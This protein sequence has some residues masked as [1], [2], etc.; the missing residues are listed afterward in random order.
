MQKALY[1]CCFCLNTV[2][3]PLVMCHTSHLGCFNCVSE[4]IRHDAHLPN[5][6]I[7]RDTLHIRFDR[8]ISESACIFHRSKRRRVSTSPCAVFVKLLTLKEKNRYKVFTRTF[9]RFV[10][11]TPCVEALEQLN[12]DIDNIDKANESIKRLKSQ[13]LYE[14]VTVHRI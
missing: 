11:A 3:N 4:Y 10:L 13:R 7:C 12:D 1:K 8:L 2:E 5:C 9:K 6:P 14:R